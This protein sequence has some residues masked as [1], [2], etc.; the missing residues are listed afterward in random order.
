MKAYYQGKQAVNRAA[1]A[2]ALQVDKEK[3][4]EGIFAINAHLAKEQ[5][6]QY[7]QRNLGFD[8]TGAPSQDRTLVEELHIV[9]FEV[10]DETNQYPLQYELPEY[11]YR[12]TLYRPAVVIV[13]N[14][15]AK[16]IFSS[17]NPVEWNI[18]GSSQL[19]S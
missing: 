4:A 14:M 17:H 8:I 19:V 11:S 9:H 12:T 15:K 1:H 13:V 5:A 16:R 7:L 6:I 2:G 18:I 3:L 10:L